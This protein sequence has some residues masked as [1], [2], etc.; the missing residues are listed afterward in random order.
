M[1]RILTT[2][3]ASVIALPAAAHEVAA[4]HHMHPH[5]GELLFALGALVG[6][7]IVWRVL[8]RR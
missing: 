7:L 5:G 8:S 4:V 1:T 2:A 6:G 3:L